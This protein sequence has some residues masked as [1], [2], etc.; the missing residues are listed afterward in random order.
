VTLGDVLGGTFAARRSAHELVIVD[1][2]G[3]GAQDAAIAAAAWERVVRGGED[4]GDGRQH[5]QRARL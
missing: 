2:T 1:L 4:V 3:T 5:L